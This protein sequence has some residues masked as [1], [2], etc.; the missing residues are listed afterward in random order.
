MYFK[1]NDIQKAIKVKENNTF[2]LQESSKYIYF[3]SVYESSSVFSNN[4]G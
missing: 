3:E 1:D 4:P 2:K